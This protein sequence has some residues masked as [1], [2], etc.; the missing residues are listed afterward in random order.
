MARSFSPA[1][2]PSHRISLEDVRPQMAKADVNKV[3]DRDFRAEIGGVVQRAISL[4][5]M[6]QKEAAAA[7][8]RDSAQV[9][10]WIAGTERPQFDALMAVERLQE[11]TVIA[12]AQVA[13]ARTSTRIE[14]PD[15]V[16]ERSA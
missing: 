10:R 1:A 8:G 4:A 3:E 12:L 16:K 2:V 13:G 7:M 9:A 6:T 11:P 14:F 5:G 15:R